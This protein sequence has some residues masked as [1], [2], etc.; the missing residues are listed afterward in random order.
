MHL[1]DRL[2]SII[3]PAYNAEN[4]ISEAIRSVQA[5]TYPHWEML[6]VEDG[7]PDATAEVVKHFTA[8]DARVRLIRQ[9]N[10]GP[11]MA[12][13]VALDEATGRWVAF[14]DSDDIWMPCKLE[15]QLEFM[16]QQQAC[17]TYTAFRR[18]RSVG[19]KEGRLIRVPVQMSYWSLLGNTAIATST[20]LIDRSIIG[21]IRMTK[22]YCD[23]FV[24]WLDILKR[25][26]ISFGLNEDLMRYRVMRGSWS[27]NKIKQAIM[28]WHTY[29]KIQ[30]LSTPLAASYFV[31]Y[32][33]NS[34]LKYCKF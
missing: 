26:H 10:T 34:L 29:R 24:L 2:V 13:Q 11:A 7:S 31:R 32:A 6:V 9:A 33:F 12:R 22:S 20:V 5:Q 30:F 28:V 3:T 8:K 14:L 1:N 18:M 17:F 4:V 21:E 23:D 19:D 15:R 27:R 25:G 16:K